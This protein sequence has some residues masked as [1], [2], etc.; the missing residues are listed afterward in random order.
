MDAGAPIKRVSKLDV[1]AEG[2][3]DGFFSEYLQGLARTARG[4]FAPE[5][6]VECARAAV[7]ESYQDALKTERKLFEKC[8]ASTHYQAQRHLF[9][10]EREVAKIPDVPKDTPGREIKKVAVIG[11]GTMG[12]GITMNFVNAG[13]PVT[14]LEVDQAGLERGLGIIRKNYGERR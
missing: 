14:V 9:F 11:A 13:V 3:D 4:F 7:N 8:K 10:A 6:I 5:Q 2:I 12:G 1:A